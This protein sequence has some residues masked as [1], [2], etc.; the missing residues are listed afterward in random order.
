MVDGSVR[1]LL[2][3]IALLVVGMTAAAALVPAAMEEPTPDHQPPSDIGVREVTVGVHAVDGESAT[4]NV[5]TYLRHRGGPSSNVSVTVR[6][7]DHDSGLVEQTVSRSPGTV[8][9]TR[10]RAVTHRITV[11]R[12]G[13][14]RIAV[15][16]YEDGERVD[17]ATTTVVGVGSLTPEYARSGVQFRSFGTEESTPPP[18]QYAIARTDGNR[19]TLNV[20]A[21]VENR[22]DD[23][24]DVR[25]RVAARQVDS[26]VIAASD[27]VSVG[28]IR[29]GRVA[30]PDVELTVPDGYNYYLD[31][32]L[33]RDGVM[34]GTA[35]GAARLNPNITVDVERGQ[36]EDGLRVGDFTTEEPTPEPRRERADR[37]TTAVGGPG[38]GVVVA[39]FGALGGALL[40]TRKRRST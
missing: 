30:T 29:A 26:E 10:E 11:P 19:V 20:S 9:G 39:L 21:Y 27:S 16:V 4:L 23:T 6:A 24:S 17:R 37:R 14:Y 33:I 15:L 5:T 2:I 25:L 40:A 31:A 34:I 22:G 35:Q 36:G 28:D 12:D 32:Y 38:F 1:T 18:V 3:V 8:G 13:D 7:T